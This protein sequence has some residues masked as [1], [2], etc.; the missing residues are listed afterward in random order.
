MPYPGLD[1]GQAALIRDMVVNDHTRIDDEPLL[2]AIYFES[3]DAPHE[4]CLFEVA[5]HFGFDTPSEDEHI[6]QIQ[7]GPSPDFPLPAGDRLRL[8]LTNPAEF[9]HACAAGW[10]EVIDL[11]RAIR[12]HRADVLFVRAGDADAD[13]VLDA[14]GLRMAVA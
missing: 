5:L 14:L 11:Q 12:R 3:L 9:H 1:S 10:P 4:E 13:K 2:V 7:F 8:F 6:F